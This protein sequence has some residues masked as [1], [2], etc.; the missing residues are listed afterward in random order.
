MNLNRYIIGIPVF[1]ILV[2]LPSC[3]MKK[4][5][6]LNASG[7]GRVVFDIQLASYLTEVIDQLSVFMDEPLPEEGMP[8]FDI[9]A[10]ERDFKQREGV[11]LVNLQSPT[12]NRLTGEFT[13]TD[14]E[15]L[16]L[17]TRNAQTDSPQHKLIQLEKKKDTTELTVRIDRTTVE[18]L[19]AQNPSLN[20][21]LI[22]NFGPASTE[23]LPEADYLDMMEFALGTES[24][25][26]IKESTL[27]I[28]INVTGKILEQKGGK[29]VDA[30]T[31][32]YSIPLLPVLLLDSPLEYSL[33]YR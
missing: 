31:V 21:P 22:E 32:R 20:N 6:Y 30:K 10:I 11:S 3:T 17:D 26:G 23:G 9:K 28:T 8:I 12:R 27:L 29:L 33:L 5:V 2:F 24:R 13:F 25:R 16:L 19:L 4:D 18:E 14:I 7:G 1:V 15:L